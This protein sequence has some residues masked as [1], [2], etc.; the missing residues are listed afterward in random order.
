MTAAF[1]TEIMEH[2][3]VCGTLY[4][5]YLYKHHWLPFKYIYFF[6]SVLE[7]LSLF[8]VYY[9][10]FIILYYRMTYENFKS[11]STSNFR[12][13]LQRFFAPF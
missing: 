3:S 10:Y 9:Y 13:N 5:T 4:V 8:P 7:F 1:Y 12:Q 11:L 6:H 2:S